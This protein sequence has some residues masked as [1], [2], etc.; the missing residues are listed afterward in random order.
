MLYSITVAIANQ[1]TYIY[2]HTHKY[3]HT[4]IKYLPRTNCIMDGHA[5]S[6]NF[7]PS[8]YYISNT[9][10]HWEAGEKQTSEKFS[11]WWKRNYKT[12][13]QILSLLQKINRSHGK[14]K[15]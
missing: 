10:I 4:L 8:P 9:A 14:G 15:Q 1:Y 3:I 6:S 2:T 7:L 5:V 13:V 11:G 12:L